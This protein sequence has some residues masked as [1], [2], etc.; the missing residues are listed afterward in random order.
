[1]S[2]ISLV[3]ALALAADPPPPAKVTEINPQAILDNAPDSAWVDIPADEL[4]IWTFDGDNR[5]VIR[6]AADFSPDH[7]DNLRILARAG[8]WNSARIHRVVDNFVTQ[9]GTDEDPIPWPDGAKMIPAA[10]FERTT[11][12]LK[13]M[14]LDAPDAYAEHVGFANGWPISIKKGKAAIAHCYGIVGIARNVLPD[15]GNG[16][17]LYM[18]NGQAPRRID[19]GLAIAGAV[20]EGQ[21]Y[22]STR[23]RGS[24]ADNGRYLDKIPKV[25]VTSV[26]MVSDLPEGERP[27]YQRFDTMSSDWHSYLA[28]LPLRQSEFY[29][30]PPGGVHLC[31]AP[32]PA[33]RKPAQQ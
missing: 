29:P 11:D 26:V 14:K 31:D 21:E 24:K 10:E 25:P 3:A 7:V 4:M 32:V 23:T 6:L 2:L 28:A 5:V 19:R 22:L 8:Y 17:D 20:I 9:W 30:V 13:V 12:G 18:I 1:M 33:R 16:G 15:T 27:Q